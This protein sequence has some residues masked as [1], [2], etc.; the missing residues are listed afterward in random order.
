MIFRGLR[1]ALS[2]RLS[3]IL[4]KRMKSDLEG[5]SAQEND[6]L[7]FHGAFRE[8]FAEFMFLNVGRL[9]APSL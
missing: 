3:F 6:P 4:P 1:N 5:K 7:S 9:H 2:F 8:E